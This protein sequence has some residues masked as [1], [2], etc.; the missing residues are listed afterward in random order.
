MGRDPVERHFGGGVREGV[1]ALEVFDGELYIGGNFSIV[2]S[3]NATRWLARWDGAQWQPA[4]TGVTGR[5]YTLLTVGEDLYVGGEL[6]SVGGLAVRLIARWDGT[7]W[8][9]MGEGLGPNGG[10]N[11]AIVYDLVYRDGQL[12]ASGWFGAADPSG[13]TGIARWDGSQWHALGAGAL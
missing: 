1:L 2:G 8:H 9:A 5:V 3:T 7:S 10:G 6:G 12:Y 13:I 11:T 4:D